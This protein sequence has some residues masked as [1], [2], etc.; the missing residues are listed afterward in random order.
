MGLRTQHLTIPPFWMDTTRSLTFISSVG[1]TERVRP[2]PLHISVPM[3]PE[4]SFGGA[5]MHLR[6]LSPPLPHDGVLDVG[7]TGGTISA[8]YSHYSSQHTSQVT[9]S[10]KP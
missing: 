1:D 2:I 9:A 6:D 4:E 3:I 10:I 5:A 8:I 7:N